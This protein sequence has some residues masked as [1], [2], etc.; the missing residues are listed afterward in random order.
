MGPAFGIVLALGAK[1]V[2]IHRFRRFDHGQ[3][4]LNQSLMLVTALTPA[5]GYGRDCLMAKHAHSHRLSLKEAAQ[6]LGELSAE[7][8][9]RWVK[10]ESMIG[11]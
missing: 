3:Q 11:P 10:P 5:I 8:F 1:Q 7:E 2:G 6:V 4:S 9:D